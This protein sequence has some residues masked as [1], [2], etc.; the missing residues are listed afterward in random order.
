MDREKQRVS[1]HTRR[2]C[3]TW[4][5]QSSCSWRPPRCTALLFFRPG[6]SRLPDHR[7]R[8]C[9]GRAFPCAR[10]LCR[11]RARSGFRCSRKMNGLVSWSDLQ[12]LP[13][14]TALFGLVT[15]LHQGCCWRCVLYSQKS[16]QR[17]WRGRK[18]DG[19][20]TALLQMMATP[21]YERLLLVTCSLRFGQKSATR[22]IKYS[23]H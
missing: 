23:L 14:R 10:Y 1:R 6:Q 19:V 3:A 21:L 9:P 15:H 5:F 12:R 4:A 20:D 2:R 13:A 7:L 17:R 18:W 16:K 22:A 8:L 11:G